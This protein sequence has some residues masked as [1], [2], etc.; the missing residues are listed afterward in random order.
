[1]PAETPRSERPAP[2]PPRRPY[3]KPSLEF[4]ELHGDQVL[5]DTC[6][7][8]NTGSGAVTGASGCAARGCFASG[9]S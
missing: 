3:E 8:S 5:F 7:A 4:I 2:V 6:K 1:M 9:T